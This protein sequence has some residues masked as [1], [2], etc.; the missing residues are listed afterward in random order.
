MKME[1]KLYSLKSL[2]DM[3][4]RPHLFIFLALLFV[5]ASCYS[6]KGNYN[7]KDL[8]S[9]KIDGI[10]SIYVCDLFSVLNITPQI[11]TS[12]STTNKY[13]YYWLIYNKEDYRKPIDTLSQ[14]A[15]LKYVVKLPVALY[16]LIFE[17]KDTETNV[18]KY[19]YSNLSVQSKYSS[20][21]YVL[22][23]KDGS[24]D[25]DFYSSLGKVTSNLLTLSLGRSLR[26]K[27]IQLGFV[28][29]AYFN[30]ESEKFEKDTR[31]FMICTSEDMQVFRISDLK[32]IGG[33]KNFFF[34]DA[35]E[36]AP[37][38]WFGGSEENGFLN[39]DKLYSY[40]ERNGNLG[41]SKFGFPKDGDYQLSPIFTK[42]ATMSPLL[43]DLRSSKFV[44]SYKK[45]NK[46]LVLEDDG[47]SSYPNDF[48]GYKPVYFG[49]LDRGMWEGGYM[50]AI[51][52]KEDDHTRKIIYINSAN[53]VY[54]DSKMF[55]KNRITDI[56][57][58]P[59]G[60][61][62]S[63]ATCFAQNRSFELMYYSLKDKTYVF[64]L[65]NKSEQALTQEDGAAL[66][67]P[68]E[69][70][71][72][73]KHIVLDYV[74]YQDPS[75]KDQQNRLVVATQQQDRYK[76]YLF[77]PVANKVKKNPIVFEGEGS[78]HQV[79]YMS[80]YLNNNDICY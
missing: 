13:K 80:P 56:Y 76:I 11:T 50:Y 32:N 67:P 41:I 3:I 6:D 65:S 42:N 46:I 52:E 60:N 36:A 22:K 1:K 26:G 75:I 21:W 53:L 10:D 27:P 78:P 64:D 77:E 70:I 24:T 49:F 44:T 66:V 4:Q 30:K 18:S 62:M 38:F 72:Y 15:T 74:N 19:S 59:E 68:G 35:P 48:K 17:V 14:E 12:S 29:Y 23:D 43:F 31:S 51:L 40:T 57:P 55:L 8:S 9:M 33:F 61:Q 58:I 54:F 73:M 25:L 45:P 71:I 37:K 79:L 69:D 63:K 20:G 34:E 47:A 28:A 2:L 5:T 16:Q 7:Y 39:G